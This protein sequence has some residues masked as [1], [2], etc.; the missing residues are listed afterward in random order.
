MKGVQYVID[1]EGEAQAVLI[2]LKNTVAS[3]R[4][5]K[6]FSYAVIAARN[7]VNRC[8]RLKRG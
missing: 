6:L 7:R 4:T 2:N 1:E 8:P 5:F 3:G